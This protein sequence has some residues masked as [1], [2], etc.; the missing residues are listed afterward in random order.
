MGHI[1]DASGIRPD[2][3]KVKA[4]LSMPEP[5]DV[6][7]VRRVLGMVNHL[8]KFSPKLANLTE[9]LRA[10]LSKKNAWSWTEIHH[11]AFLS[12]KE[13]LSSNRVLALY[14]PDRE[15]VVSSDASSY[16][17]G[18]VLLQKQPGGDWKP[19]MYASRMLTMTE[20]RYAQIEK[21]ALGVTWTCERFND[22]LLG[23]KFHI[24]TDHKPLVPLLGHKH[25]DE[26]TIRLQHFRMR[27]MRYQ[28]TISHIPGN[29]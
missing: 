12:L 27:L 3:D 6:S 13:E 4:I 10:L 17:L 28:F 14:H 20:Q 25:L 7:E 18:G 22:Y 5:T 23:K 2:P 26:L 16:G 8:S 9:P 11:R 24:H 29:M 15:T 21:E 19:V 1:I